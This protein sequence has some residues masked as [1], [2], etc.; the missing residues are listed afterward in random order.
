MPSTVYFIDL[1][2]TYKDSF[3]NKLGKL[4]EAAARSRVV[5]KRDL[6]AVKLHSGN[7]AIPPLFARFF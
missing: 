7:W 3:V 2:A 5:K 1:R 4:L 6:T